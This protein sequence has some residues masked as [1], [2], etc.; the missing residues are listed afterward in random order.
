MADFFI[1]SYL[2]Y[3]DVVTLT[4][5]D[6]RVTVEN[7]ACYWNGSSFFFCTSLNKPYVT[8]IHTKVS[9]TTNLLVNKLADQRGVWQYDFFLGDASAVVSFG[10]FPVFGNKTDASDWCL[11]MGD[12]TKSVNYSTVE[13]KVYYSGENPYQTF[14]I[15]WDA[16]NLE[17]DSSVDLSN[18]TIQIDLW[19]GNY[20][21]TAPKVGILNMKR[22]NFGTYNYEDGFAFFAQNTYS[23]LVQ[24]V[25]MRL[26]YNDIISSECY[27]LILRNNDG[28]DL[29]AKGLLLNQST[30]D[31]EITK[32]FISISTHYP[33]IITGDY[34]DYSYVTLVSGTG[35]GDSGYL[36]RTDT[37]DGGINADVHYSSL[38]K[39][40]STYACN[41]GQIQSLGNALWNGTFLDNIKLLNNNPIEN[42][43]SCL[44]MPFN[45]SGGVEKEIKIGNV[46]MGISASNINSGI[47]DIGTFTVEEYYNCYVDYEPYTSIYI[48]LPFLGFQQLSMEEVVGRTLT[49]RYVVDASTGDCNVLIL[50]GNSVVYRF[51]GS[52]GIMMQLSN[53]GL[54][55][56][57]IQGA[58][59]AV[60]AVTSMVMPTGSL[61]GSSS[62]SASKASGSALAVST[63]LK[64]LDATIN[65][66]TIM[67]HATHSGRQSSECNAKSCLDA[68]LLYIRP[69]FQIP[70][71][72]AHAYGRPC[73]LTK[74]LSDLRGFTK[75][76]SNADFSGIACTDTERQMLTEIL[77]TGFYI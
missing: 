70:S 12:I 24:M 16:K 8:I 69:Q 36:D 66:A 51:E 1:G 32:G 62:G 39:L 9:G 31:D 35:D 56:S 28:L 68:Y 2:D 75:L 33:D 40:T 20:I 21:F 64:A 52:C 17:K 67:N 13:W 74:T 76:A 41:D 3:G 10:D 73:M 25:T 6:S 72:Y 7:S 43:I 23:Y 58:T 14:K 44:L 22:L 37:T 46:E 45:M 48:Y 27:F 77:T 26:I 5:T 50:N 42:V 19:G 59:Q 30:Y 34:N 47:F 60:S 38:N 53:S 29:N 57:I 65:I 15:L 54:N 4:T 71:G 55:Q 63:G 49:L 11:G 18:A 61:N